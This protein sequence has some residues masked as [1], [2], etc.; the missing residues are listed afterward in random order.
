MKQTNLRFIWLLLAFV[1]PQ[2]LYGQ[3]Y[4]FKVLGVKGQATVDGKPLLVGG[5]IPANASITLGSGAYL[6]LAHHTNK[7]LE[8]V[9][10]GTFKV[11]DLEKQLASANNDLASRYAQYVVNE[12]TN[13]DA[14]ASRFHAKAKTGS[15]TRAFGTE[16]ITFL[17]PIDQNGVSKATKVLDHTQLVIRWALT[18]AKMTQ[19]SQYRFL[20]KDGSP[21]GLG[22]ILL[23]VN[24]NEPRVLLSLDHPKLANKRILLYQV[25]AVVN[26]ER[27]KSEELAITKLRTN[28]EKAILAEMSQLPQEPTALNK[29]ILARFFEDKGLI[30]NALTAYDEAVALQPTIQYQQYYAAFLDGYQLSSPK[31]PITSVGKAY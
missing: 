20:V 13:D 11:A 21:D 6:G 10:P 23:E 29:L 28:E 4:T 2:L 18:D 30:A 14:N 7:T 9:K 17:M 27:I 26:Q 25:E 19:P 5:T 8:M 12:L 24:T 15:V 3:N 16:A 22:N 31:L 1:L